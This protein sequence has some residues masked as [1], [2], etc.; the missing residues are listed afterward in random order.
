MEKE[1]P[2]EAKENTT[3]GI[4]I[5][6][7]STSEKQNAIRDAETVAEPVAKR[8]CPETRDDENSPKPLELENLYS[9][10]VVLGTT[11]SDVYGKL[12]GGKLKFEGRAKPRMFAYFRGTCYQ[13][14]HPALENQ[15]AIEFKLAAKDLVGILPPTMHNP[16]S[17][18][19]IEI[20]SLGASL[21]KLF[22]QEALQG[23]NV[24]LGHSVS[25]NT[26]GKLRTTTLK[27]PNTFKFVMRDSRCYSICTHPS[28]DYC[29]MVWLLQKAGTGKLEPVSLGL[30]SMKAR[31]F[32]EKWL[33]ITKANK[34]GE[35]GGQD[36]D[37][38]DAGP[39]GELA[40]DE[41]EQE[42]KEQETKEQDEGKLKRKH[43]KHEKNDKQDSKRKKTKRHD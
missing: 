43:E 26:S 11:D 21:E 2:S 30:V 32:S 12:A 34:P 19:T 22:Q 24:I 3:E 13:A 14:G 6:D 40:E 18:E 10:S 41:D 8:H 28:L 1:S 42:A 37:E 23:K 29:K 7:A 35:A 25:G 33:Q 4:A 16:P 31:T 20:T 38:E 9:P 39:E 17:P 5:Q 36:E 15:Q 27:S